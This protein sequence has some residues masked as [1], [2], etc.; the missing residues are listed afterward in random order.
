MF[1]A[2]ETGCYYVT[3]PKIPDNEDRSKAPPAR[4]E[5]FDATVPYGHIGDRIRKCESSLGVW[6]IDKSPK[7]PSPVDPPFPER[8][9]ATFP[10]SYQCSNTS[11]EVEYPP[12]TLTVDGVDVEV[13]VIL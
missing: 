2:P 6:S 12:E 4:P 8:E 3:A 13:R 5:R 1:G 10:P 9:D 7:S 11:K